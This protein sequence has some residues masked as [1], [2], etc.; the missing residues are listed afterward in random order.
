MFNGL[1]A[2]GRAIS[3]ASSTMG[4]MPPN[5][6][7]GEAKPKTDCES[8]R[9]VKAAPIWLRPGEEQTFSTDVQGWID[10]LFSFRRGVRPTLR[11]RIPNPPH[12]RA[13]LQ[14]LIE[15]E[16][17]GAIQEHLQKASVSKQ[18][19]AAGEEP[20]WVAQSGDVWQVFRPERR[21]V[22]FFHR[23]LGLF[24]R[25]SGHRIRLNH[26]G[27]PVRLEFVP[28]WFDSTLTELRQQILKGNTLVDLMSSERDKAIGLSPT[29][30]PIPD[31]PFTL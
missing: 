7:G 6:A 9:F 27:N 25:E 1:K 29:V 16:L 15:P 21:E 23:D 22:F 4:V 31:R 30:K 20:L 24:D 17:W 5:F 10:R 19:A 2:P 26:Q 12:T 3:F 18:P 11:I 8:V 28:A 13:A 14:A